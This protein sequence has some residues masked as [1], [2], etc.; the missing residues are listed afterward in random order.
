MY[1][2]VMTKSKI[3]LKT[4]NVTTTI[5]ENDYDFLKE[6]HLQVSAALSIGVHT[7]R[8]IYETGLY[9]EDIQ[10]I[11]DLRKKLETF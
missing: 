9:P 7:L 6:N 1:N 3:K 5:K 4:K 10:I 2:S 8:K 11:K